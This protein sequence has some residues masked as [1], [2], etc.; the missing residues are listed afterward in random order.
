MLVFLAGLQ[1]RGYWEGLKNQ[2]PALRTFTQTQAGTS[3]E[4]KEGPGVWSRRRVGCREVG[5]EAGEV[6]GGIWWALKK[7]LDSSVNVCWE[8]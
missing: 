8:A 2:K 5:G 4:Q 6:P 1:R 7:G 3:E